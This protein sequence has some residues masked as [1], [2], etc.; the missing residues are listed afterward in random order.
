MSGAIAGL[1][2]TP[3]TISG[4]Q[5]ALLLLPLC[6]AIAVVYKTIRCANVREVPVAAG[7][8][9]VTILAGM[10]AVGV[11]LWVLHLIFS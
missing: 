1:F 4:V 5:H 8:L 11:G 9:C 7:V 10:Y 3:M 6:L 2:T